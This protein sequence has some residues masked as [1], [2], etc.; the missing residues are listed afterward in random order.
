[1]GTLL[2]RPRAIDDME[3]QYLFLGKDSPQAAGR[4]VDCV[5]RTLETL[6]VSPLIGSARTYQ[7]AELVGLRMFPVRNFQTRLI[8]YIPT[9]SGIEVVRI[10][11]GSRDMA[12]LFQASSLPTGPSS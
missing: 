12:S 8:F 10:L 11:H 6:I 1:M 7:S 9:K 2:F 5:E 3:E 4:F